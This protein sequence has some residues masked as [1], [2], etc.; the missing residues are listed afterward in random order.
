MKRQSQRLV[1]Q[2]QKRVKAALSSVRF[3]PELAIV[4]QQTTDDWLRLKLL[5]VSFHNFAPLFN[6]IYRPNAADKTQLSKW[7]ESPPDS[8]TID[9]TGCLA[10]AHHDQPICLQIQLAL[11]APE[12]DLVYLLETCIE[13]DSIECFQFL[14]E[15]YDCPI[16]RCFSCYPFPI[17]CANL[18]AKLGFLNLVPWQ[19]F[20]KKMA[21]RQVSWNWDRSFSKELADLI[22]EYFPFPPKKLAR[23][24]RSQRF[25]VSEV[26]L[27][28]FN[29]LMSVNLLAEFAEHLA[30]ELVQDLSLI[31]NIRSLRQLCLA[32]D[33]TFDLLVQLRQNPVCK[34]LV[35]LR[36]DKRTDLPIADDDI[37]ILWHDVRE[38]DLSS[39]M[40]HQLTPY[41]RAWLT[42][43]V[44]EQQTLLQLKTLFRR[45]R[46]AF[47]ANLNRSIVC[48]IY[49]RHAARD[50][51]API[52]PFRDF[53]LDKLAYFGFSLEIY[54]IPQIRRVWAEHFFI[55]RDWITLRWEDDSV[56]IQNWLVDFMLEFPE[57]H[58]DRWWK[59]RF[60]IIRFQE[61]VHFQTTIPPITNEDKF[62]ASR[63]LSTAR[64]YSNLIYTWPLCEI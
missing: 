37:W 55:L 33:S 56:A 21:H 52:G 61:F 24:F 4:F 35:D 60:R 58:I 38:L 32:V 54:D 42:I 6:E 34:T 39:L 53:P 23:R 51:T 16:P 14:L 50:N 41:Q 47:K 48:E 19:T 31:E 49:Q 64:N 29:S 13:H 5:F 62:W 17:K 28:W 25:P 1:E 22:N 7:V 8:W 46:S 57:A 12:D 27:A 18:S 10:S 59:K 43:R 2:Q 3:P 44:V 36:L 9:L 15:T 30:V 11:K 45:Q 40:R 63:S 26:T 20:F